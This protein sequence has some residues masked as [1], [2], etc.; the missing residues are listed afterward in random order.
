MGSRN[1][2]LNGMAHGF[3]IKIQLHSISHSFELRHGFEI[4]DT[5]KK[6]KCMDSA[7]V[8]RDIMRPRDY[9]ANPRQNG[10][11]QNEARLFGAISALFFRVEAFHTLCIT[12]Y[13]SV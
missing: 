4:G 1:G 13:G 3:R 5:E 8:S 6:K 11:R 7:S 12:L 2:F 10:A 9:G